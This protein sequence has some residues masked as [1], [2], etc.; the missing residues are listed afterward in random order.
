MNGYSWSVFIAVVEQ[1]SFIRA[2]QALNVSQSA[3]SHTISKL[4][5]E[6]GYQLLIRTRSGV[7]LTVNGEL[8]MPYVRQLLNCD[9]SLQQ[10]IEKL[11]DI[12][13]GVVKIAAFHSATMLWLPDIIRSFSV[14]YPNIR[15]IVKQSGDKGIY[16]MINSGEVD[17]AIASGDAIPEGSSFLPLH[18][19]ELLGIT[20]R[21]YVPLNGKKLTVKD[22]KSND[23][24]LPYEG[25]DT[26]MIKFFAEHGIGTSYSF[27]IEDDDTILA[28]VE[29]GFGI[30][31]MPEMTIRCSDRNLKEWHV[32]ARMKRVIGLV[33]VY[34]DY[35]SPAA[36]LFRQE[37]LSYADQ[38]GII[39]L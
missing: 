26:E 5:E 4:E 13:S 8:L 21:D 27:R 39:N 24:V 9:N 16:D 20:C 33:T 37:I 38:N 12:E 15:L 22:F 32:D 35:I 17:L 23:I 19:T 36:K 1:G 25:Y 34:S 10:E 7:R 31:L 18:Q 29:Q 6:C 11:K 28:M 14:K 3:V 30:S 2:A